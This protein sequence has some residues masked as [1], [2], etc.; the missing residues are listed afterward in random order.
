MEHG[1][2]VRIIG[3]LELLPEDLRKLVAE[4]IIIT[5]NNNKAF[6]NIAFAYTCKYTLLIRSK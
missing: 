1:I 3:N 4:A 6:L 5:K 2:C